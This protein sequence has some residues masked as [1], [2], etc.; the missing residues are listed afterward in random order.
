MVDRGY[1]DFLQDILDAMNKVQSFV[2]NIDYEAFKNDDKTTYAVIRT[3]KD[4]TQ[5]YR[6]KR[7][8]PLLR[9][10]EWLWCRQMDTRI[11]APS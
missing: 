10:H 4:G 1:K 2:S 6:K 3:L 11:H 8:I 9:V 5:A 7:T